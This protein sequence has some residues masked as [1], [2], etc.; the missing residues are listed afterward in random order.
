MKRNTA[1]KILNPLLACL[2]LNQI[3]TGLLR[4]FMPWDAFRLIHQAGGIS[5][6]VAATL[7]VILNWNWIR[8]NYFTSKPVV[9]N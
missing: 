3:L 6:A 7:H 9:R 1:L 2:V 8:A 5:I 4:S